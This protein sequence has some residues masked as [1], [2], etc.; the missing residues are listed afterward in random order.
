MSDA[1]FRPADSRLYYRLEA[2]DFRFETTRDFD[3]DGLANAVGFEQT[4]RLRP[5]PDVDW[6]WDLAAGYR[7]TSF[8]TKGTEYDR[9][10]H[11]FHFGLGVPL[12]SP[13]G[14]DKPL[15]FRFDNLWTLA[16]YRNPSLI[17]FTGDRRRD[18]I[19]NFV[20]MLSQKLLTNEK[21]G[22]LTLHGIIN[23]METDSNVTTRQHADPFTYDKVVYGVQL[24]WSF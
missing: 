7:L 11:D 14:S 4:F 22:D 1:R 6:T 12:P 18:L 21:Y 20:F 3:R 23:W 2:R 15:T 17:D 24:E 5:V 13:L 16:E 8:A 19:V 10:T 9:L